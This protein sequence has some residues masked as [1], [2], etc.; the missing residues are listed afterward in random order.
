MFLT[1]NVGSLIY[2]YMIRMLFYLQLKFIRMGR[3]VWNIFVKKEL[4][5]IV[6]E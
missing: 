1:H 6:K 3:V 4:K 5:I 2:M